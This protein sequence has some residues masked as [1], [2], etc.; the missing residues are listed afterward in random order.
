[1]R[2]KIIKLTEK[3]LTQLVKSLISE[4]NFNFL[5]KIK[6]ITPKS[7][8]LRRMTTPGGLKNS[9]KI[10]TNLKNVFDQNFLKEIS[11]NK[12]TINGVDYLKSASGTKVPMTQVSSILDGLSK[13]TL[14]IDDVSKFLP[15]KLENGIDFRQVVINKFSIKPLS[16]GTP[17]WLKSN[18]LI[19][20]STEKEIGKLF[21]KANKVKNY[22]FNPKEIK[23]LNKTNISGREVLEIK[24]PTGDSMIVY[25]STGKGAPTLKQAGDWQVIGGFVPKVNDPNAVQWFI[26]NE[27]STQLTKGVNPY[28]TKLDEFIKAN[29]VDMLGK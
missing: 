4:I 24:L 23:V 26:K 14:K 19:T 1:M 16:Q 7:T 15:R 8:D 25:K 12:V 3:N 13:Q 6:G 29:G 9:D 17:S 10:F 11:K 2:K 20:T 27:A 5:N 22:K 21:D 28:L 18:W